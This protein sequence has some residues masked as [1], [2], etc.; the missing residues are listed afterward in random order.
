MNSKINVD[1]F[2]FGFQ[3]FHARIEREHWIPYQQPNVRESLFIVEYVRLKSLKPLN[4]INMLHVC[5][6]LFCKCL[7]TNVKKTFREISP[8][9]KHYNVIKVVINICSI[10]Q[11]KAAYAA[12]ISFTLTLSRDATKPKLF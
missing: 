10:E 9:D 7:L 3:Q 8:K 6:F 1:Y 2:V 5:S 4:I 11:R 12:A